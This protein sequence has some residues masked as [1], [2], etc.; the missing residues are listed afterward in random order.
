MWDPGVFDK[1]KITATAGN[2]L[3]VEGTWIFEKLHCFLVNVYAPQAYSKRLKKIF[4]LSFRDSWIEIMEYTIFSMI[5]TLLEFQLNEWPLF[6]SQR[7]VDDFNAFIVENDLHKASMG[8][9]A[10]TRVST[11]GVKQSKLDIF[12]IFAEIL[13][14]F[15]QISAIALNLNISYHR[16]IFI[17]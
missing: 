1:K 10:F 9:F 12:L 8:G 13:N 11:N 2:L 17:S 14:H 7:I 4:G 6:F 3:I 5:L 16:P 15:P